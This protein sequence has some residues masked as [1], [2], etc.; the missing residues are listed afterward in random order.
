[1]LLVFRYF[2]SSLRD[3]IRD[4][5]VLAPTPGGND[6]NLFPLETTGI[7]LLDRLGAKALLKLKPAKNFARL[8][9]FYQPI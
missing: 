1:M 9:G 6:L 5:V 4:P 8:P 3:S 7:I 2:R